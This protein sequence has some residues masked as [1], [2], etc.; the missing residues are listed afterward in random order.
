MR[1]FKK[2]YHDTLFHTFILIDGNILKLLILIDLIFKLEEKI[3]K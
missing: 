3:I 2:E 1:H